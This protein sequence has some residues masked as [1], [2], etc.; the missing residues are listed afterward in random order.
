MLIGSRSGKA[1]ANMTTWKDA[2]VV[3]ARKSFDEAANA[4]RAKVGDYLDAVNADVATR[5]TVMQAQ[6]MAWQFN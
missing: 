3:D 1:V 4:F 5:Q 6:F 2:Q